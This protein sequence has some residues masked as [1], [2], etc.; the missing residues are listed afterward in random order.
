ML[1]RRQQVAHITWRIK[2]GSLSVKRCYWRRLVVYGNYMDLYEY[3][4]LRFVHCGKDIVKFKKMDTKRRKDSFSR[5]RQNL[6]RLVQAN[7]NVYGKYKPV[8]V[9]LTFAENISDL[10]VANIKLKYFFTKLKNHIGYRVKYVCVP[11]FQ[12]RGAVHYHIVFFNL[13]F[14]DKS[15]LQDLWSNGWTRIEGVN[16]I[17]SMSAYLA[18]YLTKDTFFSQK[19]YGRRC[20]FSS[21][22]LIRPVVYYD[23]F[24]I[25][26][27]VNR[28]TIKNNYVGRIY[29]Y[30]NY[31]KL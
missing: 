6:F 24:S 1:S 16:T 21:R 8:F 20:Y 28:A 14:I 25:D 17:S 29:H 11:E 13:P 15:V 27:L 12:K 19:F 3:D 30:K 7:V 18:K 31:F 22:G 23:D 10:D 4:D 26:D 2:G 9:T 5:A